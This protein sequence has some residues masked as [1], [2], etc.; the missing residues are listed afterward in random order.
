MHKVTTCCITFNVSKLGG[1]DAGERWSTHFANKQIHSDCSNNCWTCAHK[2]LPYTKS[3][4]SA[5][6][7]RL[8]GLRQRQIFPNSSYQKSFNCRCQVWS[9]E[10]LTMQSNSVLGPPGFPMNR[11]FSLCLR[12]S[13][14]KNLSTLNDLKAR[15]QS[16]INP[17]CKCR[18]TQSTTVFWPKKPYNLK[19]CNSFM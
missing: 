4:H 1:T 18:S 12:E 3:K 17:V 5:S 14:Y 6:S 15:A 13:V 9:P 10:L 16:S 7:V 8:Q 11:E 19:C 2:T